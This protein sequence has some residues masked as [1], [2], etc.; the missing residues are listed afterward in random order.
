M[1]SNCYRDR[2]IGEAMGK[3]ISRIVFTALTRLYWLLCLMLGSKDAIWA[4]CP[5]HQAEYYLWQLQDCLRFLLYCEFCLG[6]MF[7]SFR[8]HF[9]RNIKIKQNIHRYIFQSIPNQSREITNNLFCYFT[10]IM[11]LFLLLVV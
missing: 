4:N 11:F 10:I 5:K 9:Y 1:V 7:E 8:L 3:T 6:L 2:I